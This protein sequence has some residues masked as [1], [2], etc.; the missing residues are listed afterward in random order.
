MFG[1]QFLRIALLN[2]HFENEVSLNTVGFYEV[3]EFKSR[4][5]LNKETYR[6]ELDWNNMQ[7]YHQYSQLLVAQRARVSKSFSK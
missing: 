4:Y 6:A 1:G 3:A 2:S 5:Q 7:L